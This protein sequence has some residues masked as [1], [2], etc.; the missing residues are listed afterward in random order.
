MS[1]PAMEKEGLVR[2]LKALADEG[3]TVNSLVTDQHSG[4]TKMLREKLPQINHFFDGWH[5]VKGL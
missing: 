3:V 2:G 1:S 4:I 5:V